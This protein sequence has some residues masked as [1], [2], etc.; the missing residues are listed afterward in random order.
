[1][2]AVIL[3]GGQGTRLRPYTT[4][5][6]KPLLPIGDRPVLELILRQLAGAGFTEI[7]LCIGHLGELITAYLGEATTMPPGL[8]LRYHREDRPLGTA[9]AVR[10]VRDVES[11]LLVMNGDIVT[12]L[13][14]TAIMEFHRRERAVL[15]VATTTKDVAIDLGVIEQSD[16]V[17]TDYR[18]KPHLQLAV[19][20]GVYVYSP[21]AL[22]YVP[23]RTFD[24]PDLVN[25]LLK[26]GR[27]VVSYAF[28]GDWYDIGTPVE[29][30]RAITALDDAD[31]A[32]DLLARPS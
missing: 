27:R 19:S 5:L 11:D 4:I 1:M 20:M 8:E 13:D 26:D 29:Y 9:G 3:A 15:T 2:R 10:Q 16:N 18:E 32:A 6:P 14:F 17:V 25:A 28:S 21:D 24:F 7:D 30:E 22:K 31:L 23:D 12:A